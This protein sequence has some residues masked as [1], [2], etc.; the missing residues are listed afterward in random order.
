[1]PHFELVRILRKPAVAERVGLG[2]S[3]ID[4]MVRRGEFPPPIRLTPYAIGWRVEDVEQHT[5]RA[6]HA[7]RR[8]GYTL[9]QI[10]ARLNEQGRR[11]RRNGPWYYQAVCQLL[12]R[13][14][15]IT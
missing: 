15:E 1:M 5:L 8:G 14:P 10:A 9:K 12:T 4:Q 2:K 3:T 7:M 13:H 11:T 6:M